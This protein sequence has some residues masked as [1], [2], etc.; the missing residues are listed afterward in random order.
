M[1]VRE[2][3]NSMTREEKINTLHEYCKSYTDAHSR[4]DECDFEHISCGF[5]NMTDT[6]LT[7]LC[8]AV[9]SHIE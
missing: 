8:V 3:V 7:G 9:M 6:E 5:N 1:N 4:C 2:K